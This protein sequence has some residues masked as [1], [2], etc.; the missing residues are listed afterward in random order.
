MEEM[1]AE[2]IRESSEIK[3][4]VWEKRALSD[5]IKEWLA[6]LFAHWL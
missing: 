4:E 5:K 3:Q 1:F 6:H 2:D